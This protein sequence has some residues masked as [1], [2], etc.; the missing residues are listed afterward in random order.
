MFFK[1]KAPPPPV[2]KPDANHFATVL[3]VSS[4]NASPRFF[5]ETQGDCYNILY[6]G[7]KN[8]GM[9]IPEG[10]PLYPF[11]ENPRVPAKP[12]D[13]KN[14]RT[15]TVVCVSHDVNLEVPW[16]TQE[17]MLIRD[18]NNGEPY[19]VRAHGVF[20]VTIDPLDVVTGCDRYYSRVLK[21]RNPQEFDNAALRNFL[22]ASFVN[23]IGAEMQKMIVEEKYDLSTFIQPQPDEILRISEA[24]FKRIYSVFDYVGLTITPLSKSSIVSKF[25]AEKIN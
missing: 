7:G 10:G 24:A 3:E 18:P 9:P 15:A 11:S 25:T 17:P 1:K 16:G 13:L 19:Y 21:T 23:F 14:V 12:K 2:L 5:I 4:A 8:L 20:Y 6:Q 22:L